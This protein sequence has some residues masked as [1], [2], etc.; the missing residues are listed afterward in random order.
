MDLSS[1][2]NAPSGENKRKGFFAFVLG[3]L[4]ISIL[5]G[6]LCFGVYYFFVKPRLAV[7]IQDISAM[8]T[9]KEVKMEQKIN[10]L[11][12]EIEGKNEEIANLQKE[13]QLLKDQTKDA[14]QR[15]QYV[16]KPQAK[17][18]AECYD[19]RVG[20]YTLSKQCKANLTA[21]IKALLVQKQKIIA[22]EVVGVV[23]DLKYR[24]PGSRLK[25]E[26]LASF[27]AKEV[28]V[29]LKSSLPNMAVFQGLSVQK[30]NKRG[31]FIR[32]YVLQ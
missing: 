2:N 22:L 15:L 31:F 32:A 25:Q 5:L 27:R 4:S 28:F 12:K 18:V 16:I 21:G 7:Q 26:G 20:Q 30:K 10:T 8:Q 1:N 24:G 11:T 13:N 23:D 6:V 9:S 29:Y 14:I 3:F 17:V 19:A